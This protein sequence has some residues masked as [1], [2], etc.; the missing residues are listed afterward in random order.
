MKVY[1]S[2][3]VFFTILCLES[4]I[5][6]ASSKNPVTPVRQVQVLYKPA[7]SSQPSV[8]LCVCVHL[9]DSISHGLQSEL[10]GSV[11]CLAVIGGTPTSTVDVND[12]GHMADG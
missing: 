2:K 12:L 4:N 7:I 5:P 11:Y 9:V 1:N 8:C 10:S 6:Y 3:A